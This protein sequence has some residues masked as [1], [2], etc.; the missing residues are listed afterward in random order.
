MEE[1]AS[2]RVCAPEPKRSR[3]GGAAA[4]GGYA[5]LVTQPFYRWE[6]GELVW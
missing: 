4:R 2:R 6:E 5:G 3:A 1:P